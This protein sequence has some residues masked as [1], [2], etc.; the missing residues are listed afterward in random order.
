MAARA[1]YNSIPPFIADHVAG[2]I[3][4][5]RAVRIDDFAVYEIVYGE[6][7]PLLP[8]NWYETASLMSL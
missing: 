1:G 2:V 3:K 7:A 5:K 4:Q 8:K 6:L